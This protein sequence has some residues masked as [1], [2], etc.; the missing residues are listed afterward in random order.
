MTAV[1]LAEVG[2]DVLWQVAATEGISSPEI[3]PATGG[4]AVQ[5]LECAQK[6]AEVASDPARQQLVADAVLVGSSEANRNAAVWS[7]QIAQ[8]EA[9]VVAPCSPAD[10]AIALDQ[11][12]SQQSL[13]TLASMEEQEAARLVL[14]MVR[15]LFCSTSEPEVAAG[16]E[17]LL[18]TWAWEWIAWT[19]DKR[20]TLAT[21]LV[22]G[23]A[24]LPP[25]VQA[26]HAAMLIELRLAS[27]GQLSSPTPQHR[28]RRYTRT[29][30]TVLAALAALDDSELD[31]LGTAAADTFKQ[32][33]SPLGL[34]RAVVRMAAPRRKQLRRLLVHEGVLSADAARKLFYA[35]NSADA[36]VGK[37]SLEATLWALDTACGASVGALDVGAHALSALG[38]IGTGTL[39]TLETLSS[40]TIGAVGDAAVM[41]AEACAAL[42]P[43]LAAPIPCPNKTFL[44]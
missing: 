16:A 28:L 33:L 19:P 21:R 29:S 37:S 6:E 14:R 24:T 2:T 13:E 5:T 11:D 40:T 17:H 38:T 25:A 23:V 30:Q 31:A 36:A 1:Q 34:A 32:C 9:E 15:R 44:S 4:T 8:E 26:K 41:G 22:Q 27:E 43:S 42:L 7:L 18:F 39:S 35:L 20:A 12:L 10:C 3:V